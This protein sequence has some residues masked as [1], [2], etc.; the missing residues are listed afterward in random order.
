MARLWYGMQLSRGPRN[1]SHRDIGTIVEWQGSEMVGSCQGD[2]E[3][4]AIETQV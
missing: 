4:T 3:V 1:A 2:L